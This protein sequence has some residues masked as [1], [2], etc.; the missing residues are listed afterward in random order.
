MFYTQ[1]EQFGGERCLIAVD[2]DEVDEL[3]DS[4]EDGLAKLRYVDEEFELLAQ[5]AYEAVG[6]LDITLETA[7]VVFRHMVEQL[8]GGR[9]IDSP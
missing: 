5:E 8:E 1:P 6:S 2:L 9:N 4:S 7:W 3:L